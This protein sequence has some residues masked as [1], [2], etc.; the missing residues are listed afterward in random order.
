MN[1]LVA[2]LANTA[3]LGHWHAEQPPQRRL[4]APTGASVW[5]VGALVQ[6]NLGADPGLEPVAGASRLGQRRGRVD[7]RF[8]DVEADLVGG[9]GGAGGGRFVQ[10]SWVS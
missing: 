1:I 9:R 2:I 5:R 10:G 3:A 8:F 7:E 6:R 4:L